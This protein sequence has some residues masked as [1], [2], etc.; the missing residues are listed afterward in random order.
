MKIN[1]FQR[2]KNKQLT[3]AKRQLT[4]ALHQRDMAA[5]QNLITRWQ[6]IIKE[7]KLTNLIVNEVLLECDAES[8]SW[9]FE[10]C[11]GKF[12]YQQMQQQA[13]NNVF[14][15]LVN[16]GLEP[17]KDFSFGLDAEIII[18]DR[19]K[20]VLIDHLPQQQQKFF[21]AQL[22]FA[23]VADPIAAIEQNLGCPFYQNLT[24]IAARQVQSLSNTQAAAYLGVL[25]AGLVK[26]HPA[27]QDVDFPTKFIFNSLQELPQ[28][29]V[30]AILNDQETNPQFD[31]VII[32]QDLLA[33]MEEP[34]VVWM[35]E[36]E[37]CLS[38]EQ[39]KKL[40]L[41]WCGEDM[42]AEIMATPKDL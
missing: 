10:N 8:H 12:R 3:K 21:E 33:A 5:L 40:D 24:I 15:I 13:Q 27:L 22:Q 25:L 14:H 31:Q 35:N 4:Q 29:R 11:L 39:L 30:T 38:L 36:A 20:Q 26:R 37:R 42:S 7:E 18:S 2:H 32:F 1:I 19:T 28:Q 34:E 9:F 16:A 41:V 23:K 17:G 6:K